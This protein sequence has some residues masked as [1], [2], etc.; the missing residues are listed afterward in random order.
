MRGGVAV[1]SEL[2]T[3]TDGATRTQNPGQPTI[4]TEVLGHEKRPHPCE[5]SRDTGTP[6]VVSD[7]EPT[8]PV[9]SA[10]LV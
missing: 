2:R 6:Q 9:S 1:H 8:S 3:K 10:S 5:L 7:V 4:G